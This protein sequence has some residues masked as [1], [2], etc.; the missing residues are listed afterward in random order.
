MQTCVP[1]PGHRKTVPATQQNRPTET[2]T[3]SAQT[4]THRHR[5]TC[6]SHTNRTHVETEPSAYLMFISNWTNVQIHTHS[7]QNRVAFRDVHK[8]EHTVRAHTPAQPA[9]PRGTMTTSPSGRKLWAPPRNSST[10]AHQVSETQT[11]AI[12]QPDHPALPSQRQRGAGPHVLPRHPLPPVA[13]SWDGEGSCKT[14]LVP[15]P[16][17]RE[18][19]QAPGGTIDLPFEFWFCHAQLCDLG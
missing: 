6:Q 7:N 14:I 12:A 16:S 17:P 13:N 5:C 2:R 8:G 3:T 4:C 1:T 11:T 18:P 15:V 10:R 9:H 19:P